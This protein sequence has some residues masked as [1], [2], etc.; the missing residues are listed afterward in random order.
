MTTNKFFPAG[1]E[2]LERFAPEWVI[3]D[4]VEKQRKRA[5]TDLAAIKRRVGKLGGERVVYCVD[6]RQS[7]HFKQVFGA[8]S[9]IQQRTLRWRMPTAM[10]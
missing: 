10:W 8:A 1:F 5:T 2:D 3:S 6:A 4:V 9:R 7:L